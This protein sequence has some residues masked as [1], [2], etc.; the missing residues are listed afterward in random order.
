[1]GYED[2][3]TLNAVL[4]S[5]SA[6]LIVSGYVCIKKRKVT[7]HKVCMGLAVAVS[8]A[9]LV[10]YL[11]YHFGPIEEKKFQG[12]GPIR[13]AY[14]VML[15]SHIVLAVVI[16]PLVLVTVWRALRGQLEKHVRIARITIWL[17][18]YVSVTGILVYLSLYQINFGAGP[19]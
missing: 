10:S 4:N 2:L 6:T 1:M 18:L 16:V 15:I 13:Y 14:F 11:T 19:G 5:I 7:A 3:P 8:A 9:F 17:W 12:Q